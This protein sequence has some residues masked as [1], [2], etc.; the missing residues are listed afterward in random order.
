M[1]LELVVEDLPFK[2]PFAITGHVFT[3]SRVV[4]ATLEDGPYRGRGE[5]CGVY[6]LGDDSQAIVAAIERVRPV[7]ESG[8]TRAAL[9]Q[10]L[11][12]GGAR[13]ALDC[14][15]WDLEAARTGRR[16][17]QLAGQEQVKPLITTLTVGAGTPEEMA[18]DAVAFTGA[19]AIK[20][21]LTGDPVADVSRVR[22]VRAARPEAWMG[23]DANQGYDAAGLAAVLPTFV[24]LNVKLVEQPLPRGA[25]EQL[26]SLQSPIPLA[27]D[28]SVLSA[29]DIPGLVGR[30]D[31]VNIKLDKCGGLTEAL[32]MVAAARASGL[33]VMVGNMVGSSWAMA[34]AFVVGQLCDIVDL[35]GPVSLQTDR[36]EPVEYRD[37]T[38]WASDRV[39]GAGVRDGQ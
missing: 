20:I 22:A 26:E 25:E 32:A 15:L 29:A 5:A 14:A 6:Y 2:R 39:W 37:G 27:A 19:L 12:P 16:V 21:K 9:Q 11:P 33:G 23:V 7:V 28:E 1:K 34:P 4:V 13:N 35:D 18:R 3:S 17:W 36:A 24:D 31:V 8:I 10:M 30:F 38:I